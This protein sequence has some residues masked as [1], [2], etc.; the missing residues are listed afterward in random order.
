MPQ[1]LGTVVQT[2]LPYPDFTETAKC[3]DFRRLGKQ[4]VEALQILRTIAFGGRWAHHPVVLMWAGYED[5]L[6][7][8]MNTMIDEWERRGYRNTMKRVCFF[9]RP[10]NP[11]WLGC[12]SFH[13]SHRSNLLRKDPLYY[14][15][16]GWSEPPNLSYEWPVTWE[17]GGKKYG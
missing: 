16:F 17:S 10:E 12:Q 15:M 11:P 8:Y 14:G 1:K 13:Q 6:A 9:H 5:A 3:L 4:R 2:F 7:V